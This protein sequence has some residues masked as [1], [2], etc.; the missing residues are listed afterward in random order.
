VKN[1]SANIRF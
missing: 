1:A